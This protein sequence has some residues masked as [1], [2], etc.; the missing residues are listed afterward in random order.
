MSSSYS[1]SVQGRTATNR[2]VKTVGVRVTVNFS[3]AD[4]NKSTETTEPWPVGKIAWKWDPFLTEN[5]YF[6]R[7][8]AD[9]CC[10]AGFVKLLPWQ[11]ASSRSLLWKNKLPHSCPQHCF[12]TL[13]EA[14]SKIHASKAWYWTR[15]T[16]NMIHYSNS[17]ILPCSSHLEG[18]FLTARELVFHTCSIFGLH[19]SNNKWLL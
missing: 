12:V 18:L 2:T 1:G 9:I 4:I 10:T 14:S 3:K 8:N 6:W 7:V 15:Q 16:N 11:N 19:I 17:C 5:T 13:S